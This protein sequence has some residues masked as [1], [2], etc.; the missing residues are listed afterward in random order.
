MGVVALT[1]LVST[2]RA[3]AKSTVCFFLS[4]LF[5][6]CKVKHDY[7]FT[8][9]I[10]GD[11]T[12]NYIT[13]NELT[14]RYFF[15]LAK[16]CGNAGDA[17]LVRTNLMDRVCLLIS[18]NFDTL[19]LT[20]GVWANR[21]VAFGKS[22]LHEGETCAQAD[23]VWLHWRWLWIPSLASVMIFKATHVS[24]NLIIT[25]PLFRWCLYIFN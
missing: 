8:L 23:Q 2:Y 21:S 24:R 5:V 19:S 9:S 13:T 4:S 25:I 14:C 10:L 20:I 11:D 12:S 18:C 17:L 22:Y 16:L 6:S 15:P 1:G 7:F 3:A